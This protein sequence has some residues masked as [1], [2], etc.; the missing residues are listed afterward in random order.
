MNVVKLNEKSFL[1]PVGVNRF[2]IIT[3]F[4]KKGKRVGEY[5]EHLIENTN[6]FVKAEEI[7]EG[8]KT[9]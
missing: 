5:P 7:V 1:I 6:S 2:R 3:V 8:D 4:D 9:P